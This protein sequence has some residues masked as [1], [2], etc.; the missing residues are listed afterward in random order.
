MSLAESRLP[1]IRLILEAIGRVRYAGESRSPS[2]VLEV[3][4]DAVLALA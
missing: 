4:R 3:G 1:A 2:L